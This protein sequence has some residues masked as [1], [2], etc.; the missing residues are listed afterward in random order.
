MLL[1]ALVLT[2]ASS[3]C[4][5]VHKSDKAEVSKSE[6]VTDEEFLTFINSL[7]S[8]AVVHR[9]FSYDVKGYSVKCIVFNQSDSLIMV[10]GKGEL[11]NNYYYTSK[12]LDSAKK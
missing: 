3:S 2:I 4:T 10:K 12:I 5:R 6:Y 11:L 7:D 1:V 9:K 8:T